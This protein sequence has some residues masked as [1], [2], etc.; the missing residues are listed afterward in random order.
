MRYL[1]GWLVVVVLGCSS[2]NSVGP[3]PLAPTNNDP[4]FAVSSLN[5]YYLAPNALTSDFSSMA[6]SID[7]PEGTTSMAYWIGERPGVAMDK[8]GDRFV[9]TIDLSSLEVGSYDIVVAANGDSDAVYSHRWI[10]T[11]PM[12]VV[13]STDW[14]DA[15]NPA[16]TYGFQEDLHDEHPELIITHFIGPY[17]F[18]DPKVSDERAAEIVDW[19]M[20]MKNTYQDEIGLHIHPYCNF[21]NQIDEILNVDAVPCRERPSTVYGSD[22]SGYTIMLSAYETEEMVNMFH[23]SDKLF[24][25]NGLPKPTSFRAG[26]WTADLSTL[27]AMAQTGYVA[28]TSA[29]NW[30]RM[31]E[32]EGIQNGALYAW[33]QSNWSSIN[34]TS[35]P[36][37]PSK[38]NILESG[39]DNIP[40]LEVPDNGILVDYVTSEEMNEIFDANWQV[41]SALNS[42]RAY[43]IGYH[44]P[45]FSLAFKTRITNTLT[46][47]DQFLASE[48][49]GPV[50]YARLSDLINV[51]PASNTN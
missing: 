15:D 7:A 10:Q 43:S 18:T 17:T 30:R 26:G 5:D 42:P 25:D 48:G 1:S 40:V 3:K 34:D 20:G 51:W 12:Y 45:N 23:A 33:N 36:Y 21:V 9:S 29:N 44:P 31:E 2:N 19:A 13:V 37:Y 35:Q 8:Q 14:D 22:V 39:T 47:V 6:L 16:Y 50:V 4:N 11:H 24:V 38:T 28:D 27:E 46:Y 41:G 32:W 49:K